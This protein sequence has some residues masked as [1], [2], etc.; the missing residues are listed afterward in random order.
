MIVGE[1]GSVST[2]V[3]ALA[4]RSKRPARGLR[5]AL[6]PKVVAGLVILGIFAIVAIIGPLVAPY[7]PNLTRPRS[8]VQVVCA[9]PAAPQS[10]WPH[11]FPYYPVPLAPSRAHLLGTTVFAQDV[12]SQLLAATRATLL[13]GLLAGAIATALSV[14]VGVTGGYL[15]G[16][17]DEGLSLLSNV[18][19]AIPGLPLLIV[20][21]SYVPGAGTSPFLI[22]LIVAVTGWAYGARVLRAQTLSLR[23][24]EFIEAARVSGEKRLRIIV[25]ETL[26]NLLPIVAASFLFTTLYAVGAYISLAF[27]GL[28]GSPSSSPAGLWNWGEMLREAYSQNAVG[29]GWWWWW[30]PPGVC[31]ALVGTGLALLNFG[32]DEF[33]NPRLRGASLSGRAARRAGFSARPRLGFTPVRFSRPERTTGV[34]GDR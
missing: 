3:A 22:A 28:A 23:N 31:I 8:W 17:A 14:L 19:L 20:L 24:R 7:D 18:F 5:M 4:P 25:V 30:A 1:A 12:L 2:D 13:V 26:P 6:S 27:L 33:V 29:S 34:E 10:P 9:G 15:G 11:C 32:I 16:S 21:A